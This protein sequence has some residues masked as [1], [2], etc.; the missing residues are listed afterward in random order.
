[1]QMRHANIEMLSRR[2][3]PFG[4]ADDQALAGGCSR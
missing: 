1:M 2:Q 4:A 3:K